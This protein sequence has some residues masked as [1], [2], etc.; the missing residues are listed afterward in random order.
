MPVLFLVVY[1]YTRRIKKASRAV[2]KKE[3]ELL[4]VVEEVLTSIRVVK[5]FAREDYEQKRFDA[6]SLA[7]VEA[8]LEA[9]SLKAK[10]APVVEVI[11]AIGTCLVLWYGARLALAGAAQRR[12]AHRLPLVP[13][14]DVQAHARPVEDDR[15]RLQ[16]DG[17]L[18][19]PPGSAR[20]REPGPRRAGRTPRADVQRPDRVRQGQLRLRRRQADPHGRQLH[21]RSRDRSRRLSARQARARRPS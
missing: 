19:A 16:G 6:E 8:G 11:V 21:D 17:R 4:S 13:G 18:R 20:H 3:G 1:R 2:R 7:N 10:L 14:Q 5:A 9:R 12:R 15:H